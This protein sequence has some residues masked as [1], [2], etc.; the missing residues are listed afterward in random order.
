MTVEKKIE[1][2]KIA[3]SNNARVIALCELY[4]KILVGTKGG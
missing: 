1:L 4:G 2:K 3:K